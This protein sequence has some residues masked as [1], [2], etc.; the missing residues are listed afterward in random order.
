MTQTNEELDAIAIEHDA[1][2]GERMLAAV[3]KFLGRFVAYPSEHAQGSAHVVD[4]SH[5]LDG[6]VGFHTAH[7]LS[8]A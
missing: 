8:V 1:K 3:H 5:A 7:R 2:E 6:A 4:R